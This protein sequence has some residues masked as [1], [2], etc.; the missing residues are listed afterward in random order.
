MKQL[1]IKALKEYNCQYHVD[2]DG[3]N[4]PLVDLLTPDKDW[5]IS[6]G[7]LEMELLADHIANVIEN[8]LKNKMEGE[9]NELGRKKL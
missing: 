2:Y 4:L 8:D 5:T 3:E 6:D 9:S 1:I 7:I